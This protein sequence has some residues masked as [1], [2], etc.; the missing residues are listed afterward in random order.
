MNVQ[1]FPDLFA[2]VAVR[3]S[4]IDAPL[5][6][7]VGAAADAA[8]DGGKLF[9]IALP[10]I[11]GGTLIGVAVPKASTA[12]RDAIAA[13]I[14]VMITKG[15]YKDLLAKYSLAIGIP[16]ATVNGGTTASG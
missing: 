15:Q 10:N 13:Q 2:A 16:K 6:G 5:T 9:A 11:V 14:N 7:M 12:L 8:S 1:L 4:R 3:S